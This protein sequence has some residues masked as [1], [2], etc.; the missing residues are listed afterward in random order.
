MILKNIRFF[1]LISVF[2][3]VDAVDIVNVK[4]E[5]QGSFI[6]CQ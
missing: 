3:L 5:N 1:F 2:K 4:F 6:A